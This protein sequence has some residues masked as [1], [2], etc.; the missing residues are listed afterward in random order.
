MTYTDGNIYHVVGIEINTVNMTILPRAIYRFNVIPIRLPVAFFRELEQEILK[1]VWK[2]KKT[3]N[4]R[5][6][7]EKE[8]WREFPSWCRGNESD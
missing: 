2:Y 8:K 6:N 1:F 3:L 5:S 4:N 7:L